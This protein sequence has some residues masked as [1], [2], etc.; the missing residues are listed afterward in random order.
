MIVAAPPPPTV[1]QWNSIKPPIVP[2]T[3]TGE[4]VH[5]VPLSVYLCW[6]LKLKAKCIL[7]AKRVLDI[8]LFRSVQNELSHF[9]GSEMN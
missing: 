2:P 6:W 1:D 3:T 8:S 4:K 7:K 9:P 5:W